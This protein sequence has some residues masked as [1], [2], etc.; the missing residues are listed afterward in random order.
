ML[1]NVIFLA[2]IVINNHFR[3]V[4]NK[5]QSYHNFFLTFSHFIEFAKFYYFSAAQC[6]IFLSTIPISPLFQHILPVTCNSSLVIVVL[7]L[8]SSLT[9]SLFYPPHLTKNPKSLLYLYNIYNSNKKELGN[10]YN[11]LTLL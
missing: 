1:I 6:G 3:I 10:H 9:K 5:I 11:L 4:S 8:T 7:N 2:K